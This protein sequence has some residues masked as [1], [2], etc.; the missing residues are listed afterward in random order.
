MLLERDADIQDNDKAAAR[1]Y[2][3]NPMQA[4]RGLG[5]DNAKKHRPHSGRTNMDYKQIA[6][7]EKSI[8]KKLNVFQQLKARLRFHEAVRKADKAHKETGERYYVMPTTGT[9]GQLLIMDRCNFR[10]LKQKGYITSKAFVR[11]LEAE[12]FY[13]TPYRNGKG[14]LP[15]EIVSMKRQQYFKWLDSMKKRYGKIRKH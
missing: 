1:P 11:D 9:S 2:S 6:K 3:Y 12:C 13:C 10:K 4:E 8:K 15:A 14:V 5:Y 7:M